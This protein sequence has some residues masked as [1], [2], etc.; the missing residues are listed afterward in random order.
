[1]TKTETR[2]ILTDHLRQSLKKKKIPSNTKSGEFDPNKGRIRTKIN[3]LPKDFEVITSSPH[4]WELLSDSDTRASLFRFNEV[5]SKILKHHPVP[6]KRITCVKKSKKRIFLIEQMKLL[7]N[8]SVEAN[9]FVS[10]FSENDTSLLDNPDK[11]EELRYRFYLDKIKENSNLK[12][13]EWNIILQHYS[14]YKKRNQFY[15]P[16]VEGKEYTWIEL[17]HE[18]QNPKKFVKKIRQDEDFKYEQ[19]FKMLNP[20][21]DK[22]DKRRNKIINQDLEK[23]DDMLK[24]FK[25][26]MD[27]TDYP[28]IRKVIK[29]I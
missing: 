25:Y 23:I 6:L 19:M 14:K 11:L 2:G 22:L 29:I 18:L 4:C 8:P 20:V 26:K 17:K 7:N 27:R 21:L 5:I 10:N 3:E 15:M 16:L 9:Y 24:K 28:F 1:M 12:I 13:N